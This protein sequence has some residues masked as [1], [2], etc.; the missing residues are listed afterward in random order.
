MATPSKV[1]QMSDNELLLYILDASDDL[2]SLDDSESDS[3]GIEYLQNA[4]VLDGDTDQVSSSD[5]LQRTVNGQV[6]I[7]RQ[8]RHTSGYDRCN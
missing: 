7:Y 6:F 1:F 4:D 2:S 8:P 5:N 3:A